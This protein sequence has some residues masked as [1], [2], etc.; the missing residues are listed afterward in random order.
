LIFKYLDWLSKTPKHTGKIVPTQEE[1][2]NLLVEAAKSI[3]DYS[4]VRWA[5]H[6]INPKPIYF[7]NT[8][9]EGS[10]NLPKET[11]LD[12]ASCKSEVQNLF[13]NIEQ[14]AKLDFTKFEKELENYQIIF[15]KSDFWENEDF[16]KWFHGKDLKKAFSR[17]IIGS[18]MESFDFSLDKMMENICEVG[19]PIVFLVSESKHQDLVELRNKIKSV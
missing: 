7:A 3:K 12:E 19:S 9:L 14:K 15:S 11:A 5:L 17:Q 8:W 16:I 4:A 10:G 6:K 2:K 13:K 18:K 1:I